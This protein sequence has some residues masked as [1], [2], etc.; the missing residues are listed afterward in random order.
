MYPRF[1]LDFNKILGNGPDKTI[2]DNPPEIQKLIDE[3][4][5]ARDE[6]P[7]VSQTPRKLSEVNQ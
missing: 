7:R 1:N 2:S 6:Q 4:Q 3:E 5:S